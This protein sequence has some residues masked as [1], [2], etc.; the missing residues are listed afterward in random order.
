MTDSEKKIIEFI[1]K[2]K[3]KKKF[4]GVDPRD[5]WK[6]IDKLNSLYGAAINEIETKSQIIIEEKEKRIVQLEKYI[7]K[8]LIQEGRGLK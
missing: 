1:E 8:Y 2:L 5:V 7:E 3:F 6:N 4:L